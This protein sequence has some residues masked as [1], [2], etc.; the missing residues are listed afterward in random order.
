VKA[1]K[2]EAIEA[3]EKFCENHGLREHFIEKDLARA[4]QAA[5]DEAIEKHVDDVAAEWERRYI[6]L[7]ARLRECSAQGNNLHLL[8]TLDRAE[9]KQLREDNDNLFRS[10]QQVLIANRDLMHRVA[11]LVEERK[12]QAED[13]PA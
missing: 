7:E 6:E 8:L 12:I 13:T 11:A 1:S 3:A 10:K 5:I 4:F 9:N 2:K